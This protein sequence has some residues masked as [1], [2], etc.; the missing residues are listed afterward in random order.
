[1][2][3]KIAVAI[4]HSVYSM[5]A[6]H[7]AAQLATQIPELRFVLLNIQPTLSQYLTDDARKK[8]SARAALK[9]VLKANED[10]A[11]QI[12]DS[13]AR[14]MVGRGV[15]EKRIEQLTVPRNTG[16]ADDILTIGQAYSYDAILVGRRGASLMREL[17]I[18]SVTANLVENSKVIPIWVVDGDVGDT[19][20]VL[21]AD[22]SQSALRA[23]DHMAFM[24]SGQTDRKLHVLHVQPRFQ[25]Y[26]A[27]EIEDDATQSARTIILDD[28]RHCMDDFY[29]Q[30][31]A[32]LEKNGVERHRLDLHTLEGSLSVPRAILQYTRE[33]DFGTIVMG[34]RGRS[35]SR[36]TGS[37]SRSLLQ[38]ASQSALWVVP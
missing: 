21:A 18:G 11:R 2:E 26:C 24:Y 3:K 17:V 10:K 36:F 28:D 16:V 14:R 12:L 1:M 20:A 30:T 22:G 13:A 6:V 38:K 19:R 4:D 29:R 27:I 35:K 31:L 23:L 32:V 8:L 37:V 9:K 15:D 7:Y 33:N 25:D 34:R 5:Q